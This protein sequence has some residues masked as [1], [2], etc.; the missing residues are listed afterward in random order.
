MDHNEQYNRAIVAVAR[1]EPVAELDT[2]IANSPF[3]RQHF[4]LHVADEKRRIPITGSTLPPDFVPPDAAE[5]QEK[6][7]TGFTDFCR[8]HGFEPSEMTAEQLE[9]FSDMHAKLCAA[10]EDG[11]EPEPQEEAEKKNL[12]EGSVDAHWARLQAYRDKNFPHLP[13]KI[14]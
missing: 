5:P 7:M 6:P 8:G 10:N 3:C 13:H 2:I 4:D 11:S 14:V 9:H 12:P 1:G